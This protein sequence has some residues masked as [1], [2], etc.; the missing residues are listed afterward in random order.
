MDCGTPVTADQVREVRKTVTVVFSDV[1]GSTGLG[2]RLDPEE[3]RRVMTRY[4]E[5]ANAVLTRHGGRVGKFIGDA[6]MAVFGVPVVHEDDAL[7]AVRAAAELHAGL[8]ERNAQLERDYGVELHLR[9]GVNTGEIVLA[10]TYGGQDITIGDVVN[11]AARLEQLAD[12]G[13]ILLGDV[14]Y[15]LVRDAVT[16]EMLAPLTVKGKGVPVE[17]WRL[18]AVKPDAEGHARLLDAPLIGREHELGLLTRAFDRTISERTSHL[19]TLLGTAGAGKSRMV[20]ELLTW[21]GGRAQV[22]R[23]RCPD[24][25]EGMT[26]RPLT[27]VVR[28]AAGISATAEP[29]EAR[30]R[31]AA[32]FPADEP[33]SIVDDLA[34]LVGDVATG[35]AVED[36]QVALHRLLGALA[37]SRPLIVVLDDLQWAEA[38]LLD[39]LERLT[40]WLRDIPVLLCCLAR[41][42]LLEIRPGWG[43]GRVN[44]TTLMLEPLTPEESAALLDNL[45]E[46]V[47]GADLARRRVVEAAGG[48]PLYLQEL[49]GMLIE[50]GLLARGPDGWV[51]TTDLSK[52][53]IPPSIA[54]LLA[55]RLDAL[56]AGERA[57]LE[58]ASVIGPV[59]HRVAVIALTPPEA[60]GQVITY[61]L[62]LVR[63]ELIRPE[64]SAL[65]GESALHFRHVLLRDAAYRSLSKR[66]RAELHERHADWLEAKHAER[67]A[68]PDEVIGY[69][70]EQACRYRTGFGPVDPS[71]A[72]LAE[73]AAAHLI[74][75][76]SRAF[77]RRDMPGAASLLGRGVALLPAENPERL[78]ALP[79]L[80]AALVEMGEF[81]RAEAILVE[82]V[83]AA[84]ERG[85]EGLRAAAVR[86]RSVLR[87]LVGPPPDAAPPGSPAGSA[88][89]SQD[90]AAL[91]AGWTLVRDVRWLPRS[92]AAAAPTAGAERSSATT[93]AVGDFTMLAVL[94]PTPVRAAIE[95]YTEY[96][97]QPQLSNTFTVRVLG[98]LAGL[99]AMDGNV[100]DARRHLDQAM[101]IL[102]QLGLRVRAAALSYLAGL[103][104]LLADQP[105]AAEERLSQACLDCE[106][107]GERYVLGALLSLRAQASYALGRYVEAVQLGEAAEQSGFGDDI[108]AQVTAS[109]ARA[110]ALARLDCG[111]EAEPLVREAAAAAA[112]TGLINLAADALLDLADVHEAIGDGEAAAR[113]ARE[114]LELYLRKGNV[115]SARRT[116]TMLERLRPA[117]PG[118]GS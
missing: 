73:R 87:L 60:R 84:D 21:S 4:Y 103:V 48:N 46:H 97:R 15:R 8:A 94:G 11:V 68:E 63:K 117:E 45:L 100:D 20:Q 39:L 43:G 26:Y 104:D 90:T 51:A 111:D 6:V 74:G 19:V 17:A 77:G 33:G 64:P 5:L 102:G 71:T 86:V 80:A 9:T 114:A 78:A 83:V 38:A 10:E 36:L 57:V 58:R 59:F 55:A 105:A 29:E 70:L 89:D 106:R 27:E 37:A 54:A 42:D 113:A 75:S 85:D 93:T 101:S 81:G 30:R 82:A 49:V 67:V 1:V 92:A 50:D 22:L 32:L 108:V 76:G 24:Y 79:D 118:T 56:P 47:R 23:G 2:E 35:A 98:A 61:L 14:T 112:G 52:L 115:V 66:E 16:A 99:T 7:R 31:I 109:G 110:K 3:L 91:A 107:M 34:A 13:E 44:A 62:N 12:P 65:F 116:R 88:P 53:D 41:P 96:L 18:L 69:H 25:G 72:H 40:E 95:R 28:Q